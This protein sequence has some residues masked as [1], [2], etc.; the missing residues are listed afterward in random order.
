MEG[1]AKGSAGK[2]LERTYK[3]SVVCVLRIT[4]QT[5]F[6]SVSLMSSQSSDR[7]LNNS[8][9]KYYERNLIIPH[10][11]GGNRRPGLQSSRLGQLRCAQAQGGILVS[12]SEKAAAH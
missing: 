1:T 4:G 8:V 5:C 9:S 2:P 6:T 3:S 12:C 7:V 10:Q 11:A